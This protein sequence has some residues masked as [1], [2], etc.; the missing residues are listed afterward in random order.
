MFSTLTIL[1]GV[2][3]FSFQTAPSDHIPWPG[4][5]TTLADDKDDL[6][7]NVSGLVAS[8]PST[9]WAVRDRPSA[10]LSLTLTDSIWSA[11]ASN[12]SNDGFEL[13][14]PDGDGAPDAEGV[15]I[16]AVDPGAVYVV[17]ERDN[18]NLDVSRNSILRYDVDGRGDKNELVATD[19]WLL[20]FVLPATA[21]NSGVE[22]LAWIPDWYSEYDPNPGDGVF[23]VGSEASGDITI[24]GLQPGGELSLIA[25]IATGLPS[26]MELEWSEQ[27]NEL[28]AMCDNGCG[29]LIAVVHNTAEGPAVTA[30]LQ[31]PIEL[32]RMNNE[33]LAVIGSCDDDSLG[34]VWSD[35][36][37]SKGHALRTAPM[38]CSPF[39]SSPSPTTPISTTSPAISTVNEPVTAVTPSTTSPRT[40]APKRSPSSWRMPTIIGAVVAA[41]AVAAAARRRRPR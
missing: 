31:P 5:H 25:N 28:W 6:G 37:A 38:T 27:R 12:P 34:V 3:M 19:E 15:A 9:M 22:G 21:P 14:Y 10:L 36:S 17:A 39:S 8:G 20:D 32:Q 2:S 13:R 4:G 23:A 26:I 35:D 41:A 16:S 40:A 18:N 7:G 30:T 1:L 11:A 24:V 29:G 33:G